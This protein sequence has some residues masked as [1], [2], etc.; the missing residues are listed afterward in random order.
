MPPFVRRGDR[1]EYGAWFHFTG[2]QVM[3]VR[4]VLLGSGLAAAG[5]LALA[6]SGVRADDAAY[7]Q[8]YSAL[9]A[10][11]LCQGVS[12][13]QDGYQKVTAVINEKAGT[14]LST[15]LR[16]SLI[17]QAKNDTYWTVF[18]WGCKSEQVA[19]LLELYTTDLEPALAS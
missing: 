8:Y 15:G 2:V 19:G 13:D 7:T 3:S 1:V 5:V 4:K 6:A 11:K 12:L 16:L 9:E 14:D 10:A 18:K 17:D